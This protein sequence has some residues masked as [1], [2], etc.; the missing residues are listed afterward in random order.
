MLT[1][2]LTFQ[3]VMDGEKPDIFSLPRPNWYFSEVDR[4]G[5]H[6]LKWKALWE[7][8]GRCSNVQASA[9]ENLSYWK[10]VLDIY[11]SIESDWLP[12]RSDDLPYLLERT[13][14]RVER[15]VLIN[16]TIDEQLGSGDLPLLTGCDDNAANGSVR[17]SR[18]SRR[19][20]CVP[21]RKAGD[22]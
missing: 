21:H 7:G 22:N 1:G 20:S 16:R 3:M 4:R 11:R 2:G 13:V 19:S 14:L 9:R 15:W 17:T 5:G 10:R 12:Q 6:F 8:E 18:G